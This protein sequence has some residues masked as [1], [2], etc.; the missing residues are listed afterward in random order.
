MKKKIERIEFDANN[1]MYTKIRGEYEY[2]LREK[3]ERTMLADKINEIIDV[4][5]SYEQRRI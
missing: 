1:D 2:P 5:N 3:E 4:I